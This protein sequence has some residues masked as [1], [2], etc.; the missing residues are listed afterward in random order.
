[1]KRAIVPLNV[2]FG[3]FLILSISKGQDLH[4]TQYNKS[5]LTLN[6][7]LTGDF[8]GKIRAGGLY[9][10]QWNSISPNFFQTGL[11]FGEYKFPLGSDYINIGVMVSGDHAGPASLNHQ[12]FQVAG[13]YHK[14]IGP[15][16]LMGGL[17]IGLVTRTI[18]TATY[19]VQYD[20]QLGEFNTDLPTR[21]NDLSN[22][23]SNLDLNAGLAYRFLSKDFNLVIGQSVYHSNKPDIS[24]IQGYTWRLKPRWVT[25]AQAEIPLNQKVGLQPS[26]LYKRHNQAS[27]FLIG[28]MVRLGSLE[29]PLR[30]RVGSYYRNNL[31]GYKSTEL[32]QNVDAV[33]LNVGVVYQAFDLG[34]AYD[35]NISDLN[36]ASNYRGGFEI[37]LTYTYGFQVQPD[38]KKVPCYRY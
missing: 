6:P 36:K 31:K 11:A 14:R 28:S 10:N 4:F 21:E 26:V 38:K 5:P 29:K 7:S 32:P 3:L 15:H 22:Q 8:Q 33:S 13:S 25:H 37:A 19:P 18:N 17:Q 20:N 30:F 16:R 34:F 24:L 35:F 2:L 1:M 23:S 9:R 27:E 12:M